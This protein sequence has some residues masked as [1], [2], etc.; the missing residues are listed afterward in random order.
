MSFSAGNFS[1]AAALAASAAGAA[2]SAG[3]AGKI[4]EGSAFSQAVGGPRRRSQ[5]YPGGVEPS[6]ASGRLFAPPAAAAGSAAGAAL[7]SGSALP[8]P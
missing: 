6:A 5:R 1:S 4:L 2:C 7:A 8:E 3:A